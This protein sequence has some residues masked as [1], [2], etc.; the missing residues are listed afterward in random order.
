M[1]KRRGWEYIYAIAQIDFYA[2]MLQKPSE[3]LIAVRTKDCTQVQST[4]AILKLIVKM[5]TNKYFI[6][7]ALSV[8]AIVQLALLKTTRVS[9]SPLAQPQRKGVEPL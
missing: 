5:T 8:A 9:L 7:R 1:P 2:C 6:K 4:V 3:T